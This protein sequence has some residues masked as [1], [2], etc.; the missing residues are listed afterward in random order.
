M[1]KTYAHNS[2]FI[3]EKPPKTTFFPS[4][5]PPNGGGFFIS[6]ILEKLPEGYLPC[7]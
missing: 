5:P 2:I 7:L 1:L 3:M 6:L 4:G